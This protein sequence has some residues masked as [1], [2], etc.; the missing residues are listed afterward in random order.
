MTGP[1]SVR[2][3]GTRV[4]FPAPGAAVR[5]RDEIWRPAGFL[6]LMVGFGL[7]LDSP[8]QGLAWICLLAGAAAGGAG[9]WTLADR[10]GALRAFVSR[11]R[12]E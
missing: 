8:W 2:A 9:L 1:S 10:D 3:G 4:V 6:L 12:R 11:T 7:R 5:V